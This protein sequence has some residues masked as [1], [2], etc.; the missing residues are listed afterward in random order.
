MFGRRQQPLIGIKPK[1]YF[2]I[3]NGIDVIIKDE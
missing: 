2:G 3:K 1:H